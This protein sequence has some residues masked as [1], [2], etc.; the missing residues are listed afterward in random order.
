MNIKF[1]LPPRVEWGLFIIAGLFLILF[2]WT[3]NAF[4]SNQDLYYSVL[5]IPAIYLFWITFILYHLILF[6]AYFR[7]IRRRGT[8]YIYDWIFGSLSFFG[9]FFLLVGGIGAMYF[10][11][12]QGLPFFF[13]VAQ[14]TLYHVGV[15]LQLLGLGY[16]IVTE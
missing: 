11:A 5:G 14:I 6:V 9:M 12:E 8:H 4:Q 13:N 15:G 2:D 3:Q 7:A 16:F 10:Q 1:E